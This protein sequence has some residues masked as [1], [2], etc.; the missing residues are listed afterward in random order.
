MTAWVRRARQG[1]TT[2]FDA[3]VRR[4][5]AAALRY[6]Q[7]CHDDPD[8]AQDIVQDAFVTAYMHLPS[9]RAPEAFAVWLRAIIKSCAAR[10]Q[11]RKQVPTV[12]LDEVR[13]LPAGHANPAADALSDLIREAITRLPQQERAATT[14]FYTCGFS[15]R[16]I[17]ELLRLPVTT[18]N[19]RLAAS[20]RRRREEMQPVSGKAP[21]VQ[22]EEQGMLTYRPATRPLLRG[23]GTLTFRAMTEAD[24][25]A[26]RRLDREITAGL[27][28]VNTQCAPGRESCPGGP[29]AGDAWLREHF[30]RYQERGNLVLLACNDAGRLVGFADI[31]ATN[32]PAPFGASANVE[33]LDYLWEYYP[34]GIETLLLQE[35]ETVA[36]TAG[37]P[38][39]DIGSNTHSGD[40]PSLRRFGMRL[41]YEYDYLDCD[42]RG[43]RDTAAPAFRALPPDT[44]D[45][46]GLL[47]ISHWCPTDFYAFNDDPGRPG[48]YE[49]TVAGAR[50]V[51]DCWRRYEE[52]PERPMDC[53]LFAAPRVLTAPEVMAQ[54][55]HALAALAAQAGA[56]EI[57]LPYPSSLPL[58]PR[59]S[60][61]IDRQF[62]FAW[63]RK[64]LTT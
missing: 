54:I 10:R 20:R 51:A 39:L 7:A 61:I 63:F 17:A 34:L 8:A 64:E 52:C 19:N 13:H 41:F 2:A 18:V 15:Q 24:L 40:Y 5:H 55:L 31:W 23:E 21:I 43:M 29:W 30:R 49:F 12:P 60:F 53:E 22:Q 50:V 26:M 25:P 45:R 47:R 38:S 36:R 6:A 48:V 58:A 27:D 28:L 56:T 1:D 32:E 62:A 9:L 44:F 35:A 4:C 37:L 16:E 46:T 33:C 3:L 11:R 59:P 42:V 57:T 14:L